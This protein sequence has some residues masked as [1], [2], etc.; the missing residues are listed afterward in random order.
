MFIRKPNEII[1]KQTV[2]CLIYGQSGMGKT[3]LACSAPNAV[4]FD[5][6]NGADRL[7]D[8]HQIPT[9]QVTT[10]E[11]AQQ[12]LPEVQAGGYKTI[13]ID[14]ASKLIDSITASVC[15]TATPKINQYGII[16]NHF[17]TF[18][19]NINSMGLNVLYIC[20]REVEK[21]GDNTRYVPQFRASNYKDVICD[22]DLCGYMEM[23]TVRGKSVRHLTF[24]P[25]P[26]S[27]G[28]NTGGFAPYYD[29]PTLEIGQP[30]DFLTG[31]FAQYQQR[32]A[33][34]NA[35]RQAVA[36]EVEEKSKSFAE[37]VASC[38]DAETL[39]GLLEIAMN[40]QPVGDLK[41]RMSRT[42]ANKAA[43]LNLTFNREQKRYE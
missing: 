41:T 38:Q 20:Q 14:T 11:E 18:N 25:T 5:F 39:N 6:D 10:F 28:K 42:I 40:T 3:T 19:R 36:K 33:E 17:K 29:I 31:I 35:R 32:Q 13:I 27:E 43:E 16:N 9:V 12:A 21:D 2:A 15:G 23:V 30:N 24:D 37:E 22:L 26:R 4:L 7:R 8:E 34:K 1:S